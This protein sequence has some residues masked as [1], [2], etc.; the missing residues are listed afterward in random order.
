MDRLS[1]L[2]SRFGVR[3]NLFYNDKLCGVQAYS[4]VDQHGHIH[5][6][7]EGTVTVQGVDKR[8]TVLTQPSLIFLPRPCQHRLFAHDSDGARLLCASM[9]FEGGIDNPL[10]ASLPDMLVLPLDELPLLATTLTWMFEEAADGQCGKEAVINRLFELLIILLFRHLLDQNQLQTGLMAGLADPRLAHSLISVHD[11]PYHPWSIAEM[12]DKSN[13]SR[14]AY[15]AHFRTIVGQT[16]AE[17][18]LS[19]RVSLAQKLL[20]EGRAINLIAADVG[21]DSPSAL[22]RAFRRKTGVSP[23]EWTKSVN[24]A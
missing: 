8:N 6:L 16:P 15:A 22:A 14:S 19:W 2:M 23:R 21:Y 9:D 20:R 12:A 17:Y 3:A 18:L 1:T 7:K 10:S 24:R 5:L 13:M 4:G 11:A